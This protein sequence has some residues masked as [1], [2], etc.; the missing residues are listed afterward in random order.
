[1]VTGGKQAFADRCRFTKARVLKYWMY[2]L[3]GVSM[4]K[5]ET[6][7]ATYTLGYFN[8]LLRARDIFLAEMRGDPTIVERVAFIDGYIHK[9]K[10]DNRLGEWGD[11]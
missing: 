4:P 10:E 6:T 8:G 1:M 5:T 9:F 3:K 11:D 7:P 2:F